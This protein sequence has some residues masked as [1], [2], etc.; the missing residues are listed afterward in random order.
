M[1]LFDWLRRPKDQTDYAALARTS[2]DPFR[3]SDYFA[4]AEPAT[5]DCWNKM[6]WPVIGRHRANMNFSSVVDLAA[7]HGRNSEMLKTFCDRI[8]C[9]DINGECIEACKARFAGDSRFSFVQN[10]GFSLQ[11]IAAGSVTFLFSFDAMVHF[12]PEV[13]KNYV[14]EMARVLAPGGHGF[15]HHSN[16]TANAGGDFRHSPHW[17]NYM[18]R[19]LFTGYC[20]RAG[21]DIV[22]SEVIDWGG[23]ADFYAGLDCLT[24]FR[25]PA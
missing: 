4:A 20:K 6:I 12:D 13:V 15:V 11:P 9:V 10:D 22:E 25:K 8:T 23:G 24:L 7:G 1:K 2:G 18:S 19:E 21:L 5:A 3:V 14:P 17:R 16:Y